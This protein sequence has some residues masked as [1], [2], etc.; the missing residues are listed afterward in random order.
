M[1]TRRQ[2]DPLLEQPTKREV[3]T[4]VFR[5]KRDVVIAMKQLEQRIAE[6][7]KPWYVKVRDRVALWWA[8]AW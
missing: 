5:A 1:P 3:A 4:A 8:L 2:R 6:L 7:E